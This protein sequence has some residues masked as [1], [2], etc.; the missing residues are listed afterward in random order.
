M[1]KKDYTKTIFFFG[2]TLSD[3]HHM[4]YQYTVLYTVYY[5]S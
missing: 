3:F 2:L 4:L 5:R 1:L